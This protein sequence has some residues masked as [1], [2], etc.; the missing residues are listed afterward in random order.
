MKRLTKYNLNKIRKNLE[1][2]FLDATQQEYGKGLRWYYEAHDFCKDLSILYNI[3]KYAVAG[4]LS[5]LS[6]R[7]K[8]EKNKL[9][10]V[11]VLDALKH[12]LGP[13]QVKVSTFHS[14][15]R[16]AFKIGLNETEITT[17]SP[18]TLNFLENVSNLSE[19][20][21][22]IDVWYI[23]ACFNKNLKNTVIGRVAYEQIKQLTIELSGEYGVKPYEFQAVCWV[24]AQRILTQK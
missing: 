4:I 5:A 14:N 6:P 18:K 1:L 3:N 7:N 23:R 9:D 10:V 21:V 22:T 24:V 20:H 16:K 15:K 17:T 13:D 8:W 2:F 19:E 11:T 12:N